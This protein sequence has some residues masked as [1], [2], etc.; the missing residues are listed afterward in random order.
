MR[1]VLTSPCLL[2]HFFLH[3]LFLLL[4]NSSQVKGFLL[5]HL[6]WVATADSNLL[7]KPCPF[8]IISV[9]S[10]SLLLLSLWDIQS[11]RLF[12]GVDPRPL[13]CLSQTIIVD[14]NLVI[15]VILEFSVKNLVRPPV[16]P[17][18]TDIRLD[19]VVCLEAV[20]VYLVLW[21]L[22]LILIAGLR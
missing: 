16:P 22:E 12:S 9:H 8:V 17:V 20:W 6:F 3:Y 11:P 14:W 13:V 15:E 19:H 21:W 18:A 1:I 2:P 10:K 5:S 7:F 4:M